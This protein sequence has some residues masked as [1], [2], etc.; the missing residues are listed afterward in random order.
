ML[1][2]VY[3][4]HHLVNV[5]LFQSSCCEGWCA[6]T[7][8]TWIQCTFITWNCTIN[9]VVQLWKLNSDTGCLKCE[10]TF[11]YKYISTL[12]YLTMKKSGIFLTLFL[13]AYHPDDMNIIKYSETSL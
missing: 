8:P 5:L 13:N 9:L 10:A 11:I 4:I 1:T 12:Y 3:E 7:N 6:Q 2:S